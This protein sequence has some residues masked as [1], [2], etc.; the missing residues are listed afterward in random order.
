MILPLSLIS[1]SV[2][3]APPA[4]AAVCVLPAEA[5]VVSADAAEVVEAEVLPQPGE[6]GQYSGQCGGEL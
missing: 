1:S 6:Q 3:N 2:R 4:S 5:A